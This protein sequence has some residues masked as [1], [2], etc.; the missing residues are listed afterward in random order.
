M[1]LAAAE[2]YPAIEAILGKLRE[3]F[4]LKCLMS[5]SGSA[6]FAIINNVD[7]KTLSEIK[8]QILSDLGDTC[9]IVEAK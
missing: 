6:C 8:G 1:Q 5:G 3:K 4:G 9:L 7:P 2:K